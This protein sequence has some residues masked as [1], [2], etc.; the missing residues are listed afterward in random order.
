MQNNIT[1]FL[2][3]KNT[4]HFLI[5][6]ADMAISMSNI[7]NF[8]VDEVIVP[9][10]KTGSTWVEMMEVLV[11]DKLP[12]LHSVTSQRTHVSHLKILLKSLIICQAAHFANVSRNYTHQD[13][14]GRPNFT[15]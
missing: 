4:F 1:V 5:S 9:T 7:V 13:F 12:P 6:I 3:T 2:Y 10:N 15:V 8:D 11:I 14:L